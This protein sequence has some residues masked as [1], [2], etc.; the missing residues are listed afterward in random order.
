MRQRALAAP[1]ICAPRS[2]PRAPTPPPRAFGP[3]GPRPWSVHQYTH[4]VVTPANLNII[5]RLPCRLALPRRFLLPAARCP[6][7]AARCPLPAARCPPPASRLPPVYPFGGDA[8]HKY[9]YLAPLSARA[10]PPRLPG[11]RPPALSV[12]H[13]ACPHLHLPAAR[14]L[15]LLPCSCARLPAAHVRPLRPAWHASH[16][17]LIRAW[18]PVYAYQCLYY[19]VT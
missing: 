14:P 2:H 11:A 13:A 15:A 10:S 3:P 8:G 4:L 1:R 19:V 7:P 12:L 17:R 16:L 9:N 18:S 6:L 5:V